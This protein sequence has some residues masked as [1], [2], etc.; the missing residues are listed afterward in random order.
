[1]G[2]CPH[3]CTRQAMQTFNLS[4]ASKDE[5]KIIVTGLETTRTEAIKMTRRIIHITGEGMVDEAAGP[6][7]TCRRCAKST[8]VVPGTF[9]SIAMRY[10]SS[11]TRKS[12]VA[13]V[14]TF[15]ISGRTLKMLALRT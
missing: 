3:S 7:G 14:M 4:D 9:V 1:M 10:Q 5:V 15:K 2:L 12:A 6:E 8:V 13:L 11:S